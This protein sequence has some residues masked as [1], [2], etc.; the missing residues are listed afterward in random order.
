MMTVTVLLIAV[1]VAVLLI[2]ALPLLQTLWVIKRST[3]DASVVTLKQLPHVPGTID[4][5]LQVRPP[6]R[7]VTII[8]VEIERGFSELTGVG[9][10][11]GFCYDPYIA[12]G[13]ESGERENSLLERWQAEW[14]RY[15]GALVVEA[16]RPARITLPFRSGTG[17][18]GEIRV[19]Y[20]ENIGIGGGAVS[21]A[22]VRATAGLAATV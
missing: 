7:T 20:C 12:E 19:R 2:L 9:R 22:K 18:S 15:T 11:D 1:V 3:S 6:G 16:R 5:E 17:V 21:F 14:V 8:E 4:F 13:T 10:P